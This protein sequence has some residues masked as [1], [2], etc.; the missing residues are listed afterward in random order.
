MKDAIFS[1]ALGI[2]LLLTVMNYVDNRKQDELIFKTVDQIEDT[3]KQ[4]RTLINSD[5]S[6]LEADQNFVDIIKKMIDISYSTSSGT[7]YLR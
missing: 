4:I 2:V 6:F 7:K 5:K 1:I 3:T